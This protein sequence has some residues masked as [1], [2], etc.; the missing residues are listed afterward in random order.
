MN[1]PSA[2][3]TVQR[4]G[5]AFG[6]P[7][8]LRGGL[9]AAVQTFPNSIGPLLLFAAVLGP[10]GVLPGLWAAL[11][12]ASVVRLAAVVLRGSRSLVSCSRTASLA[13]FT[14]LVLQLARAAT[15]P[16]GIDAAA[17]QLGLLAAGL[18]FLF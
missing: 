13:V 12:T 7:S 16:A 18:L 9:E 4:S 1:P 6:W 11:V 2:V 14:I 17:L 5:R 15:G 8:D 3:P 10:A